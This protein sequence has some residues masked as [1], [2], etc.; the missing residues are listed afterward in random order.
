MTNKEYRDHEGISKSQLFK[1][2]KSPAHFKYF[3]NNPTE[4]SPALL[5]GRACHKY[6][7]EPE[8][9]FDEFAIQPNVDRRTKEGK[10]EYQKFLDESVGKDVISIVDYET[11]KEMAD[12]IRNNKYANTLISDGEYEQSYFWTDEETGEPCKCRPDI[13]KQIKERHIIVDYKTTDDAETSAF[14]KSAIKYGYD[15]QAGMYSEG[16][17]K[18]TG[19][20][21][22]F[23]FLAQ[24]KKPPYAINIVE[25]NADF[26]AEGNQLFHDLLSLMHKCKVE[27]NWY[28]YMPDGVNELG[29]PD[30]LKREE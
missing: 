5:F 12:V 13:V 2:T 19:H 22:M 6:I 21:Y 24:E 8:T 11:I 29:L 7:L 20:D 17:K 23:V 3:L 14:M 28:G 9:F 27:D 1:I 18:N 30:W 25:C 26:M 15:L 16:M 10:T 4:D